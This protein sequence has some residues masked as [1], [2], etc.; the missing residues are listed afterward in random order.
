[1]VDDL[2]GDGDILVVDRNREMVCGKMA[3]VYLRDRNE[4]TLKRIYPEGERVLLEPAHPTMPPFYADASDVQVQG[5][6]VAVIR[7]L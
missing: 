4:T 2:I 1:M 3:V 6:P 5:R 7:R